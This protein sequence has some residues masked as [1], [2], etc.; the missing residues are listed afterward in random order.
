MTIATCEQCSSKMDAFRKQLLVKGLVGDT[1]HID[2]VLGWFFDQSI[3][4]LRDLVGL[5]EFRRFA[6]KGIASHLRLLVFH[7]SPQFLA[8]AR[9]VNRGRHCL[10]REIS[11]RC[12]VTV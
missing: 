9:T 12:H 1:H 3:V 11:S 10:L 4:S 7:V 5:T 8:C 2:I 6:S